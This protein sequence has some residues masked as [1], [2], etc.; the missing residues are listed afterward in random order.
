[1]DIYLPIAGL[2]INY[3]LLIGLGGLVGLLSGLFGVGGGFLLTP[4]LIFAGIPPTIAAASD[5]N[6]IVAAASSGA[7][8]YS[9][10]G[11]VDFKMGLTLLLGGILGGSIGVHIIKILS[12]TGRIDFL[13]QSVYVLMLG[14]IGSFMFVESLRTLR[15]RKDSPCKTE[16]PG[17]ENSDL[18]QLMRRIPGQMNFEKSQIRTSVLFPLFLGTA[19]GI[20]AAI[21][22]VGGGFILVPTMIY[23]LGIPTI[24]AVG[25]SL[26][27]IALT[28][29]NLTL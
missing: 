10:M 5:S 14:I 17:G 12:A 4:L 18:C 9:R 29:I 15:R 28:C 8:A 16:S 20:L 13:I 27:Q 22:G 24:V 26:F 25:T 2:S 23:I 21:M 1:M 19:V 6:Q 3:F 11:Y 7:Y